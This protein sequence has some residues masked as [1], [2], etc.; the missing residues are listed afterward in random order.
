MTT[1]RAANLV[2]RWV[3]FYTRGLPAAVARRRTD[4]IDADLH[5][6]IAHERANGRSERF[7]AVSILSRMGR[8]LAADASWRRQHA[9]PRPAVRLAV[10]VGLILL[11][12]LI[13]M[14][15]ADGVVWTP[16]DFIVAGTLLYG[17]G[18]TYQLISRRARSLPY[19][20]AVWRRGRNRAHARLGG[21][22]RRR[23][24]RGGRPRAT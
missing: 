1:R 14:Q 2:G 7:I 16:S 24:R 23:D 18:L 6:H 11:I 4:E 9:R 12:P 5:D 8:G 21:A 17:A 10:A 19:R 3:R 20:L 13:A 22:C 15:F